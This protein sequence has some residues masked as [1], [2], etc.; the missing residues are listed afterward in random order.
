[1]LAKG[2]AY[3]SFNFVKYANIKEKIISKQQKKTK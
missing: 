1:M 3:F 2:N